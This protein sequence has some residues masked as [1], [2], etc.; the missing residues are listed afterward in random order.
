MHGPHTA[1]AFHR[2]RVRT[3]LSIVIY[4]ILSRKLFKVKKI[5]NCFTLEIKGIM[6]L[7]SKRLIRA[8]P[9]HSLKRVNG[10]P[11]FDRFRGFGPGSILV[12]VL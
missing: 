5:Y 4:V 7:A 11:H 12:L 1:N 6:R 10:L 8:E 2:L 3:P 9:T